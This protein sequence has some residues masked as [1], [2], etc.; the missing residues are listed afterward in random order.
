MSRDSTNWSASSSIRLCCARIRQVTRRSGSWW[1]AF[2]RRDLEAFANADVP[3]AKRWW[4]ASIRRV[5]WHVI[6]CSRSWSA[7]TA[8]RRR[9]AIR[10]KLEEYTA[11]FDLVFNFTEYLGDEGCIDVRLEYGSDLFDR[12]NSTANFEPDWNR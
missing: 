3:F 6:R 2:A 12:E 10:S 9:A 5:L 4:S 1:I 11:K 8:A 7:I